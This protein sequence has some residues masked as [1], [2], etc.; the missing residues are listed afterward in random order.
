MREGILADDGL[1]VLHRKAGDPAYHGRGAGQIARIDVALIGKR[2]AA[3]FHGHDDF[4][5]R[6]IARALAQAID[7][8]L[9]LTHTIGEAGQ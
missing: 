6:R 5:Q 2:V 4:F 9:N 8:A 1:V 7:G 3:H